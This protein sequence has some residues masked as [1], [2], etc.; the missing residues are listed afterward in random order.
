MIE[1]IEVGR[2]FRKK[3]NGS[4]EKE[5]RKSVTTENKVILLTKFFSI[6]RMLMKERLKAFCKDHEEAIIVASGAVV[7]VLIAGFIMRKNFTKAIAHA[8]EGG[9]V[10]T[11]EPL[12]RGDG[13]TV[14]L[15][16]SR[17]GRTYYFPKDQ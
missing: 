10:D 15:A 5:S 11:V 7:G 4:N 9:R 17:D 12:L 1:K 14:V 16:H 2:N 8:V 3:Y 6:K 13:V